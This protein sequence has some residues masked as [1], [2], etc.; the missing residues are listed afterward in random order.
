VP[1]ATATRPRPT[2]DIDRVLADAARALCARLGSDGCALVLSQGDAW[3]LGHL[4]G[5]GDPEALGRLR[6][7]PALEPRLRSIPAADLP[8]GLPPGT[9]GAAWLGLEGAE[10][11][12]GAALLWWT[13]PERAPSAGDGGEDPTAL[14]LE[15][16]AQV[17]SAR[18]FLLVETA[19]RQWEATVDALGEG[20]AVVGT[21]TGRLLRANW[22][23][24][25]YLG[26]SPGELVGEPFRER[27]F[28]PLGLSGVPPFADQGVP[29]ETEVEAY[30][31]T[32]R[33]V[34]YPLE[35]A[36]ATV[37]IL[38]DVTERRRS[39]QDLLKAHGKIKESME[40]LKAT[41]AQLVQAE[42]MAAVGQLVS[43]VA[44]EL[45]NP[46]TAV[47]GFAQLLQRT[48]DPE[49]V[50]LYVE[51]ICKESERARKIVQNLLTFARKHRAEKKTLDLNEVVRK[52][53]ELKMYEIRVSGIDLRTEL[54]EDVPQTLGDFHQLQQVLLNLI[55]NAVHAVLSSGSKGEIRVST[56]LRRAGE[57]GEPDITPPSIVL[58]V[59][60]AGP[61][62]P[63]EHLNRIFEPF[64][65]TKEV[66]QGTGLGLSLAYG[67]VQEHG[68][69][70]RAHSVEGQGARFTLEIPVV[71]V[72]PAM[73]DGAVV[74]ATVQEA[75]PAKRILVVDDEESI[76]TMLRE[77]LEE[78][79]HVV[80][81]ASDGRLA[82]ET[83]GRD[84][85]YDLILSD[86]KMPVLD[87]YGFYD[88][89]CR[90]NPR[91]A[92]RVVFITGDT[93]SQETRNFLLRT[94]NRYLPKPLNLSQ[95]RE[96]LR[97]VPAVG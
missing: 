89:L 12:V 70:I 57:P 58:E 24:A 42:K 97:Q 45:N 90:D 85:A 50:A 62:I 41:Q 40:R 56:R 63:S 67:I 13:D 80:A 2:V 47:L 84:P 66:G 55:N 78:D 34:R 73:E 76:R 32:W 91:L 27:V 82:L 65:T 52:T 74:D 21:G 71:A 94:G 93:V 48:Q 46:L 3:R 10:G 72:A 35:E 36:E 81:T 53:L 87:G 18:L 33:L 64:F 44:H 15:I 43:G 39:H 92:G 7:D 59:E 49:K 11:R 61:G 95:I 23:L 54:S 30:G 31:R 9:A 4:R 14:A 75:L 1:G 51:T 5:G 88:L 77:M 19:K 69:S 96:I 29:A 37:V 26:T 83:L 6:P 16:G 60:D 17:E 86:I 68:G 79:G 28:A 22:A 25:R 20:I 38:D 8:A